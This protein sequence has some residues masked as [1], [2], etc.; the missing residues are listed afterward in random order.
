MK[1]IQNVQTSNFENLPDE[2]KV[3]PNF[4]LYK[5]EN[6]GGAKLAKVPYSVHGDIDRKSTRLN[7]SH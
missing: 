2:M 6:R 5:L 3:H 7:S 1:D 4:V